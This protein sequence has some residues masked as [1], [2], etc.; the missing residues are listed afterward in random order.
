MSQQDLISHIKTHSS[1]L[2]PDSTSTVPVL[3]PASGI[4]AVAFDIYGTLIISGSGDISL[5]RKEDRSPALVAALGTAGYTISDPEAPWSAALMEALET[6]RQLRLDEGIPYP[7]VRIVEVWDALIAKAI[8]AGW[9]TGSGDPKLAIVDYEC[10]VNPCWPMPEM[11]ETLRSLSARGIALGIVSNAQFYTPLMFPALAG[12]SLNDYGFDPDISVWS[13]KEREGKPST[14]LY[15]KLKY[16]LKEKD[17]LPEET[18]YIGNDIRNDIWP[19][20]QLG[21][22]TVLFAGDKRSLRLREDDP[23][24]GNTQ[25]EFIATSLPQILQLLG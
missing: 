9:M 16:A 20:A 14:N 2:Q 11:D 24:C 5:A 8:E 19:A 17:I 12:A 10:R 7:E 25:P 23:D 1:A 18:L 15:R 21:F 6:F 3:K 22:R 4:K 13:Y